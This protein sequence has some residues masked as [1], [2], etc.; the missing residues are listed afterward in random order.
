[1][2]AVTAW[3]E[4]G[5]SAP[6]P[7]QIEFFE[8]QVRPVLAEKC[9]SC[10]G[11]Q[12]Q[13]GGLRLDSREALLKGN[14]SGPAIDLAQ[15]SASRLLQVLAYSND[16]VQM[17]PQGKL[18]A[19]QIA[20][21]T[22]WIRQGAF[23]PA[24]TSPSGREATGSAPANHW[25][26]APMRRPAV[27]EV[28]ERDRL[29]TPIDAF[30]L[31]ALEA[32][33]LTLAPPADRATFL[34]RATFD[35]WGL[36][37][38]FAEVE[39]FVNDVR[40]DAVE[41]CIDRLLASPRYGE[42]WARYWLDVAR[43][44]DTKG[45]VFT[46][47]P[48]YPYAYTYRDYVIHA[49]N[50]DKPYDR[51]VTEQLAADQLGL[52]EHAPELA[53]LGFLTV[54]R[55]FLNKQEDIIDDRIDVV[56]RGLMALT[57][58]CARCHD[59]K[60]DPVP[61]AD[62][63]SLYG[64]FASCTEP[65]DLPI[66]G[67]PQEAAEYEKFRAELQR[68]EQALA[69]Y[70]RRTCEAIGEECRA[71][72]ASYLELVAQPVPGNPR[73]A[74]RALAEGDPRP[75]VVRRWQ[76]F[77]EQR[78]ARGPDPVFGPWH[79][80]IEHNGEEFAAAAA[81]WCRDAQ[82]P[83]RWETGDDRV[84]LLVR[85]TLLEFQPETPAELARAYGNLLAEIHHRW[86]R[87][88]AAHPQAEGLPHG[89][90][91]ELRQ[92]LYAPGTPTVFSPEEARARIFNRAERDKQRQLQRQIESWQATSP[93]APPR[94]MIVRDQPKPM[95]PRVFIRGNPGRPGPPVPRQFLEVV[96][97]DER[98]P[99]S[100]GSGRL[101]LAQ[102]IVDPRNPLT[103]RVM[104]NR[105]WQHHFGKGLVRSHGDFGVRGE[106]PTHPE[107]LDDLALR[108]IDSGWSV[109]QLHR[110]IMLSAVYQQSSRP[111]T[112]RESAPHP[113]TI[114]PEN[115]LLWHFPRQRLDLEALRDSWLYVAQALDERVA[116]RPFENISDP[117]QRRRT[118][119]GLVN[120]ND[121]P[122]VYRV[123]DFADPDASAPERPQTTVPQQAL[124]AMN[125]PFVREQARRVM[126]VVA[127]VAD[128]EAA[129]VSALYR[130][131]L[132]REPDSLEREEA[133]QF[134]RTAS[135]EGKM[136]PWE[137]LAQVLLLTNEFTFV[138]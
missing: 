27:P 60:F 134:V 138:D 88:K 83:N 65:E 70:E 137:R 99:F 84:N 39:E 23:W 78:R 103:A 109:K 123:F 51:F 95:E 100:R 61:T 63:Y 48:R 132:S 20:A 49:F 97:G 17:P 3:A 68:R 125:S 6:T 91:E 82:Q 59:H 52:D 47:E 5:G 119:Y 42:R 120:R 55:R 62:Y 11:P 81:A 56:C 13:Q 131:V 18:P 58:G 105:V 29:Q 64:V 75:A 45:Y 12:K 15:L 136:S 73:D 104:V 115:R 85:Q 54:G 67:L 114:D 32:Q 128:D 118:I 26:F 69:D 89:D 121:L 92:V 30:I 40:P 135:P 41:R 14:D 34:R 35:L 4:E 19:D 93:G 122:G 129:R 98:Q 72:I 101:E 21:L 46:A 7:A 108:F 10:H 102:S 87:W 25:A 66:I 130:H 16:D 126:E 57:V 9:W 53:A 113:A 38:T 71:K 1:L 90:E 50:S 117:A 133:L 111:A 76:E 8:R 110:W 44:A 2:V 36:P 94:A 43:Y 116:G 33:G 107:L 79:K 77:L 96:A 80:L 74:A 127:A 124:F 24:S 22:E 28:R 106:P 112:S 86:Q 37:P 31:N